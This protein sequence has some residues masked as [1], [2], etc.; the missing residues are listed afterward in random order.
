MT[1][2]D[3]VRLRHMVE[4]AREAI[5]F[6][7]G[8]SRSDLDTD[9]MPSLTLVRCIEIVGEA[10]TNVSPTTPAAAP[11][12]P[13]RQISRMRNRLIHAY[14]S[15]NQDIVWQTVSADRPPLVRAL[16]RFLASNS[17]L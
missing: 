4:A 14:F 1:Q 12:V 7:A 15:I 9:R 11:E 8:R 13:W 3:S 5:A 16:E 10:A 2:A 6:A 17:E